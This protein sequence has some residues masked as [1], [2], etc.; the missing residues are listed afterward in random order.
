M[1]HAAAANLEPALVPPALAS[2]P[3]ADAAGH[4][5]L[6]A[7]LREWEVA[8][9]DA[10]LSLAPIQRLDHVQQRALHVP[11]GEALVDREPLDLAEIRKARCLGR[12]AAVAAAWG[13]DV[14]WGLLG[15]PRCGAL[16]GRR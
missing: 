14:D 5:E 4:V 1:D 9:P 16:Q 11:D 2:H 3:T 6:E 7:G 10:D 13:D 15:C 12:V 8:G